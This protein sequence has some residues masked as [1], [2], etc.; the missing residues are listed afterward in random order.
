MAE[1]AGITP[2]SL[3]DAMVIRAVFEH[4]AAL[5][6]GPAGGGFG[7]FRRPRLAGLS[8]PQS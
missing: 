6:W 3:R 4:S 8:G 1:G 7:A 5:N 2:V